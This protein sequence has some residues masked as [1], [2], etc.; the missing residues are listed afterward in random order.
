MDERFPAILVDPTDQ[1]AFHRTTARVPVTQQ[2][3]REHPRV[4][5]H[6]EVAA[7]KEPRQGGDGGMGNHGPR[8]PVEDQ[9]PGSFAVS[10]RT[11]G[12]LVRR[13]IEVEQRDIHS[14]SVAGN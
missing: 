12:D 11:L 13:E 2:A 6:E 7:T 5:Q 8:R 4:V 9:Q 1:E 3:R 14:G 10:G